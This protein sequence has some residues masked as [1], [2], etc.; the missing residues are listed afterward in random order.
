MR[1]AAGVP[2][3]T[4]LQGGEPRGHRRPHLH[5][6]QQAGRETTEAVKTTSKDFILEKLNQSASLDHITELGKL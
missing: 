6:G 2:R 5:G 1:A 4:H 3:A